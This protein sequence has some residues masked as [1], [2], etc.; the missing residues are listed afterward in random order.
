MR[1][2]QPADGGNPFRD[3]VN[4]ALFGQRSLTFG[5]FHG[6]IVVLLGG[7]IGLLYLEDAVD[8]PFG[9]TVHLAAVLQGVGLQFLAQLLGFGADAAQF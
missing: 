8:D 6:G 9:D 5:D 4:T 7:S 2:N 1:S 3:P